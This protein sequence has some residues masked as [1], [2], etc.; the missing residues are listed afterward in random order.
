MKYER[1]D[2]PM[3]EGK[4]E[5]IEIDVPAVKELKEYRERL[6]CFERKQATFH[7]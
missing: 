2:S 6:G 5:V 4:K 1:L 7:E 3:I